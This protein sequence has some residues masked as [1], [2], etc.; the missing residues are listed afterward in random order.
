MKVSAKTLVV[1]TFAGFIFNCSNAQLKLSPANGIG[2]DIKKVIDDYPNH[3][4]NLL[5]ELIIQNPQ[6]ADYQC[7]FK[8]RGAEET[9]ITRYTSVFNN[10]CSWQSLILTTE[11]FE[12]AKQKFKALF[13]QVNNLFVR[14][15]GDAKNFQLKGTYTQPTEEKKF[16]S[17][18]FTITPEDKAIKKLKVEL[19]LQYEL[20]EWKVRVLVYDKEREDNE[21]GNTIEN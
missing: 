12:K 14:T 11:D 2:N 4:S 7:N 1:I 6:S 5:G 15:A 10:I 21:K 20:M 19:S 3:F 13:H 9:T 18:L 17:I 16:S 8:V